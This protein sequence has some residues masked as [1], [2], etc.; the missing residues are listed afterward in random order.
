MD[1]T[2]IQ[3]CRRHR[4]RSAQPAPGPLAERRVR[5]RARR[6][7]VQ[8]PG[9]RPRRAAHPG[10]R[11]RQLRLPGRPDALLGLE[12]WP[13]HGLPLRDCGPERHAPAL[14]PH[15]LVLRARST[16]PARLPQRPSRLPLST[17]SAR[18]FHGVLSCRLGEAPAAASAPNRPE[19]THCI[20][21]IGKSTLLNLIAGALEPSKGHIA[22]N[23]KARPACRHPLQAHHAMHSRGPHASSKRVRSCRQM[24][25]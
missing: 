5:A 19:R 18:T 23:P 22:R 10:L 14:T 12:L 4:P 6:V 15:S 1:V 13:R 17:K 20:A 25:L 7:R 16:S 21:G 2:A 8:V 9:A 11:G 3:T 24:T